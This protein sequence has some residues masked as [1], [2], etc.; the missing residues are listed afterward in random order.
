MRIAQVAPLY[1]SVPPKLYG[2]TE[3]VVSWLTEELVR[4]GHDVTL[5][6]SADSK[7]SA[8]LISAAPQALR[9]N[10]QVNEEIPYIMIE[11]EQVKQHA[12]EFDFIHW[13]VDYMSYP[14]SRC[15]PTP[16]VT[17]LHGRLDL[18][19]LRPLYK[20]FQDIP[21]ISISDTQRKPL[22]W[23][24][25]QGTV[26]HGLPADLFTPHY[27]QGE[28]LAVLGRISPEKGVDRAIE[29]AKRVG[30][31]L[32]IAAKISKPD[33]PY[34]EQVIKPLLDHPLIE[35]VGEI[36]EK[37]K[38]DFIGNAYAVLFTINWP[39]PFG[40]VM[41]EAM[42]CGTP[43]VAFPG[44]SVEEV[45]QDGVTGY[46]VNSVEEAARAV[47]RVPELSRLGVRKA[48]EECFTATRMTRNYLALYRRIVETHTAE[49]TRH[50]TLSGG[51]GHGNGGESVHSH[52]PSSSGARAPSTHSDLQ[53]EA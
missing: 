29:I 25:W 34:Y 28:Y 37:Q 15:I 49:R 2:G 35:F 27:A 23:I 20:E 30:M 52:L 33:R 40:I 45:E 9:L 32:R 10:D 41:I 1:E 39:E 46:I 21:V 4:M 14:L 48:F 53:N 5:F 12:R 31:P 19:D 18:P 38:D 51:N 44:G 26:H 43:V 17:T 11:L 47:E 6:A 16:Q 24:N 7:T 3:R 22:P 42:A 36:N 13:H 8:R 50:Y